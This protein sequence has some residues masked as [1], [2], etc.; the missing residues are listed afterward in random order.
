MVQ[1]EK[2]SVAEAFEGYAFRR[3]EIAE[4]DTLTQ[5]MQAAREANNKL[6]KMLHI[7]EEGYKAEIE[8]RDRMNQ[9]EEEEEDNKNDD[10]NANQGDNYWDAFDDLVRK[11]LSKKQEGNE[12]YIAACN[13]KDQDEI[14]NRALNASILYLDAMDLLDSVIKSKLS[15]A[16][17]ERYQLLRCIIL[18]NRAAAYNIQQDWKLGLRAANEALTYAP[19]NE[20][21]LY[22]RAVALVG[23][24]RFSEAEGDLRRLIE[25]NP[26]NR[27]A[28]RKLNHIQNEGKKYQQAK[29]RN[30]VGRTTPSFKQVIADKFADQ[31]DDLCCT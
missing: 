6:K 16:Q 19:N 2:R 5:G 17:N 8:E 1:V 7:G 20:K 12:E 25:M 30:A 27:Q 14:R 10:D 4:L 15:F 28:H 21:G 31:A 11:I 24:W 22:R 23:L 29:L 3:S 13:L 18:L 9:E 26:N